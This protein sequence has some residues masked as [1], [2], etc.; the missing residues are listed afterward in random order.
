MDHHIIIRAAIPGASENLCSHVLWS[1]TAYP[2][3]CTPRLLYKAASR[4][5]RARKNGIVLCELCNNKIDPAQIICESCKIAIPKP[6]L[7]G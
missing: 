2:L 6:G 5:G 4:L 7:T 1:R 3:H